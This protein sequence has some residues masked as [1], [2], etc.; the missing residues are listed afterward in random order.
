M[1]ADRKVQN[2]PLF[3][4]RLVPAKEGSGKLFETELVPPS[5]PVECLGMTF[6]NDDARREY[7]L[8]RLREA[9]EE[10]HA[11]L[12]G[13]PFTTIDEVV[14]L[15]KSVEDWPMGSDERLRALAE[16]MREGHRKD[17][18][19][20]VLQLWKD[21]VGFPHGSVEE[22]LRLSDPPYYTPFPNPF[23]QRVVS[24]FGTPYNPATD[25][26]KRSPYAGDVSE[27]RSGTVYDAHAYHTKVPHKAIMRYILH[28]TN[29]GDLVLDGF[30]GTGMTGVAA[31]L[32][33]DKT[34]IESLG[35]RVNEQGYILRKTVETDESGKT[36]Q[37]WKPFSKLGS[38]FA[39]LN[40]LSPVASFIAYNLNMPVDLE[41]FESEAERL[42]SLAERE[43]AWMYLTLRGDLQNKTPEVWAMQLRQCQTVEEIRSFV[44]CH[45]ENF[46]TVNY[47]IWSDVFTCPDCTGEV[48]FWDTAVDKRAGKVRK[49]F[50]C[51]K[52]DA[53]LNKKSMKRAWVTM[54]DE[55]LG[56][57][58]RRVKRVPV[59]VDYNVG[60]S[61]FEKVPDAFD[62]ALVE[63]IDELNIPY[64]YPTDP[65]PEGDKTAEPRRLGITHVHH[66]YTKRNLWV[67]S[68]LHQAVR[69]DTRVGRALRFLIQSYNLTHS[70]LMTR[71]IFKSNGS[72]PTLS[73]HQSGTLYVSSLPVEKNILRGLRTTKLG[74]I[75]RAFEYVSMPQMVETRT[76]TIF[77]IPDAT[78]DYIFTDPP[79]GGNMM[80][81]EL[82][83]LWESWMRVVTN[84]KPEAVENSS[85]SKTLVDYQELMTQCFKEYHRVLK[86]GRWMTVEFHNS[87]N[88]VWNAIQ[89][90]LQR[91]GF[92]I[93]DVRTL[94]K[95]QG[96]F[97][98][99]TQGGAVKQDIIISCYKPTEGFEKRFEL[100]A[101][102]EEGVW[103][104]VRSHLDQL[105]KFVAREGKAEVLAERLNYVLY[106]RMVAFHVQ[107][108]VL[109][110][111][112]AAEFYAGLDQ[113]FPK[114]DDMYFLPEQVS[115]YEKRRM[116]VEEVQQLELFVTDE[117][118]AIQWLRQQL[119]KKPQTFQEL[120]P[121]F[122][123]EIGGWQKH[124]KPL[125][126]LE[127]LEQ[128]FL[129]YDGAGEVPNQI[130]SY[131]SSNFKE[132]RNLTK[133][134]ERLRAKAKDR[135]Y[136][137]DPN[138]AADLEK[139]RERA[140]LR[141]FEEYRESKQ[142]RLWPFR[143]EAVR[144][145]FKKAWQE[146]DYETIISV[147]DKIPAN[148]LQED[149]KL[150][151]WYDQALTRLGRNA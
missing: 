137:P 58:I 84:Q 55:V 149:A 123:R 86:P 118:S 7:F 119:S 113:R 12:G 49:K 18:S 90:A 22:I 117:A 11:K 92:V 144:A 69:P 47:I 127:L 27:S 147:A 111:M 95:K 24:H 42:L 75:R 97:N 79:F 46:G 128:N 142:K 31:Q 38:R 101:G 102:S 145:G 82:N 104:F 133:D 146:R 130:H 50:R 94:D 83:F 9:L 14:Q 125:E 109:V 53:E 66:F 138:K 112:S 93:A 48:V 103:E 44:E 100:A 134:D 33:G 126:L 150:L 141:E 139:L 105:P 6:E 140:L 5:G 8:G 10:L 20:D 45:S 57:T 52:C 60:S 68:Q 107:R 110:P 124:E 96:S 78:I 21:E 151:M 37:G 1:V 120:H 116:T 56:K 64:W 59:L 72:K 29:P 115:E 43:S 67:L 136:V 70:T 28:Y 91:A 61:R 77:D 65:L 108:G 88:L 15:L 106:D 34:E 76:A 143:L 80:Y 74:A 135:W 99:V 122:M 129:K 73:G 17:K 62:L 16:R 132:L 30:A 148:I 85:Q 41:D 121:R 51:P 63:K 35:Y 2:Q 23:A 89:E 87:K 114:R 54:Y 81:S 98:Q 25:D 4:E 39:I 36:R 13:V 3:A 131:L 71:I 40:D 32:C 19:K 26:Y